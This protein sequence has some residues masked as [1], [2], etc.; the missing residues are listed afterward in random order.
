MQTPGWVGWALPGGGVGAP[1]D[2]RAWDGGV[3]VLVDRGYLQAGDPR[4]PARRR[5]GPARRPRRAAP[6]HRRPV[7][8]ARRSRTRTRWRRLVGAADADVLVRTLGRGRARGRLD[9]PRSVG[10]AAGDRGGPDRARVAATRDLGDGVVPARRSR[11]ARRRRDRSTRRSCSRGRRARGRRCGVP[12]ERATL[13]RDSQQLDDVEWDRRGPRRVRRAAARRARRDPRVRDPRPRRRARAAAPRVG[14]RAGAA[15]TQ[16][17]PPLHRRPALARGGGRVRGAARSRRSVGRRVRRRR[18]PRARAPTCCS[19]PRCSTT[20][21]RAGPATTRWSG[22]TSPRPSRR[23]S[24]STTRGPTSWPGLVRHHLLLADT[25]TRRD[26]GDER[27]ISRFADAVG[28]AER[29]ALLYALTIGDS[30]ATGPAAWSA[31]KA[32]LVRELF[33]KTDACSRAVDG[34]VRPTCRRTRAELARAASASGGRRVPRRDAGGVR[35]RVRAPTSW[36]T[37]ASS[38]S[39]ASARSTGRAAPADGSRCTVVAA[40]PH[41]PPRD[42]RGGARAASGSTSTPRPGYSHPTGTALEVFTGHDRF[43]RLV[44]DADRAARDRDA[45]RR[46]R[47]RRSRSTSSCASAPRRYR[48]HRERPRR[49]RDVRVLVDTDA[50]EYATVVEVHAPDDVGL[51][52]RVARGVRR[53]RPRRRR[54][55]SSPPSAT[56]SSTSSTC[57][58]R[59]RT[60]LRPPDTLET[61]R[62]RAARRRSPAVTLERR[63]ELVSPP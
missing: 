17:V 47:R 16:R 61:A 27:T 18:R 23:A 53:P 10:P 33:V 39:P 21:A 41:R 63:G 56:G 31:S 46:A 13:D 22:S 2:G 58:T 42:R 28:D 15:A 14:A 43:G 57:A 24:G 8:P 62:G 26:L 7:R 3:A 54:R 38:C 49:D 34:R 40:R 51:L 6:G 50:S 1:P 32:A 19:S 35:R 60:K 36:R 5:A 55:R 37:T 4:A 30:R 20:S 45:H 59:R 25:A 52:A 44:T 48:A 9:H 12:F 29:N 11:R